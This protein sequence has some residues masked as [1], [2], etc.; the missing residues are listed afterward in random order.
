MCSNGNPA[1]DCDVCNCPN[2]PAHCSGKTPT[3]CNHNGICDVGETRI[4]CSDCANAPLITAASTPKA[5]KQGAKSTTKAPV[6]QPGD[7]CSEGTIFGWFNTCKDCPYGVTTTNTGK[8][9][10]TTKCAV[11]QS[12]FGNMLPPSQ[13]PTT[14]VKPTIPTSAPTPTT[15]YQKQPGDLCNP[16][17]LFGIIGNTCKQCQYPAVLDTSYPGSNT[18][19]CGKAPVITTTVTITP[20]ISADWL[21]S[22]KN[23]NCVQA[24]DGVFSKSNC[25]KARA[26][27]GTSLRGGGGEGVVYFDSKTG[28]CV[29]VNSEDSVLK[30]I[31]N[32][33]KYLDINA[34]AQAHGVQTGSNFGLIDRAHLVEL[35]YPS[36][37]QPTAK[38]AQTPAAPT[39]ALNDCSRCNGL[40]EELR[41]NCL[42]T[43]THPQNIIPVVATQTAAVTP[44]PGAFRDAATCVNDNECQSGNCQPHF[45]NGVFQ[46]VKRCAPKPAPIA[47]VLA[48]P[49]IQPASVSTP[50]PLPASEGTCEG[51]VQINACAKAN[52]NIWV[53]CTK[54]TTHSGI[55]YFKTDPTCATTAIRLS[56]GTMLDVNLE[57]DQDN[58]HQSDDVACRNNAVY[59]FGCDNLSY[60]SCSSE[61]AYVCVC[62]GYRYPTLRK[63]T[64]DEK[65]KCA[66]NKKLYVPP[67]VEKALAIK[68][69]QDAQKA[70]E[71]TQKLAQCGRGCATGGKIITVSSCINLQ[72]NS[73]ECA[74]DDSTG[75]KPIMKDMVNNRCDA[76]AMNDPSQQLGSTY[77]KGLGYFCGDDGN[78][79]NNKDNPVL[80]SFC[81]NVGMIC[82]ERNTLNIQCVWPSADQLAA[83]LLGGPASEF[84]CDGTHGYRSTDVYK[85]RVIRCPLGTICQSEGEIVQCAAA[86]TD[87]GKKAWETLVGQ[88]PT[89]T[90]IAA[91]CSDVGQYADIRRTASGTHEIC[92]CPTKEENGQLVLAGN[93]AWRSAKSNACGTRPEGESWSDGRYCNTCIVDENG[94]GAVYSEE[95]ITRIDRDEKYLNDTRCAK[96]YSQTQDSKTLAISIKPNSEASAV[97]ATKD[98]QITLGAGQVTCVTGADGANQCVAAKMTE[99]KTTAEIVGITSPFAFDCPSACAVIGPGSGSVVID[100]G[101]RREKI[102]SSDGTAVETWETVN[103]KRTT[104]LMTTPCQS[105]VCSAGACVNGIIVID[106][107]TL[108]YKVCEYGRTEACTSYDNDTGMTLSEIGRAHV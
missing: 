88:L 102:C 66:V 6:K 54:D 63:T 75:W 24:P 20:T 62:N 26:M 14:T 2:P 17:L 98:G 4:S 25:D 9:K 80:I 29:T 79:Y 49:S 58:A 23:G 76:D 38:P 61:N 48:P 95:L 34:C 19:V 67:A 59:G 10:K 41:L 60:G 106:P 107:D 50:A 15:T 77:D 64:A 90:E 16:G 33:Q 47:T 5:P 72:T 1:P 8:G 35:Q 36:V 44:T 97:V 43:C 84:M 71:D 89:E 85:A 28:K 82:G 57:T 3:S 45:V 55:P 86:S 31:P 104:L 21:W 40:I 105:G 37:T 56:D 12:T 94:R 83:A 46:N 42:Y 73:H 103:G 7:T 70:Q 30:N 53:R 22:V 27:M 99:G 69:A 87:A 65:T 96:F 108:G 51:G 101:A 91:S 74:C 81:R 100:I 13:Q 52:T 93:C 32:D 68:Q 18:Y 78:V 39:V 92:D 11:Q